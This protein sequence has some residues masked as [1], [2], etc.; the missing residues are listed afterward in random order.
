MRFSPRTRLRDWQRSRGDLQVS[1]TLAALFGEVACTLARAGFAEPRRLA[2]RLVTSALD[3]SPVELLTY[4]EQEMDDQQTDRVRLVLDRTAKREPLSRILGRREFWGLEFA[5]SADTFDP[6]PE[7]E[8]IVE[9]VVWR[10]IDRR[11]PLR[12]LDLGTGTGCILLALLS[13]LPTATGCGVDIAAG[14]T[15]TA[16]R[17]AAALGLFERA[18]FFVGYWGTAISGRFDVIVSNPPYIASS[19]FSALPPEVGLYDPSLAL[20]GGADGLTAYCS[21]QADLSRLL[22][23]G[24]IFVCEVGSGQAS[25]VAALLKA[26]G[27]VIEK[28]ERDLAGIARCLVARSPAPVAQKIVGMR[29][30]PV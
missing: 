22:K 21:L 8:T 13:E 14:A 11:A 10:V 9:A 5:L 27:L 29:R 17:N 20:D 3:L 15:M 16:R 18:H 7:T 4:P 25:T 30:V 28:C 12:V 2:R 6:R 26:N 19:A 24:A 23:P 1:E